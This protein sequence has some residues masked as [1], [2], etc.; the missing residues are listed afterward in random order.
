M[1][2]ACIA[3]DLDC[4]AICRMSASY[5]SRESRFAIRLCGLCAQ[6]CEACAKECARH[7][8]KHCQVCAKACRSCA[9]ECKR[10]AH[11]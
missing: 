1:M 7:P 4:A 11:E 8:E 10:I 3:L 2:A 9:E 6:V 5:M